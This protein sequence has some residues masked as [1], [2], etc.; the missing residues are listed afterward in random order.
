LLSGT[1]ALTTSRS[2]GL[3][4]A[5]AS[6]GIAEC[7]ASAAT[8]ALAARSEPDQR[9]RTLIAENAVELGAARSRERSGQG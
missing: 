6:L 7:A 3:F 2:S 8:D 4:H 5:A 1:R 9:A